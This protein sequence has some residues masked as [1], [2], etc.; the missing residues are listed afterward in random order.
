MNEIIESIDN[1]Q[2]KQAIDQ[3]KESPYCFDDLLE[4]LLR[5]EQCDEMVKMYRVAVNVNYIKVN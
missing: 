4:E 5:M 3:L 1:G 2:R